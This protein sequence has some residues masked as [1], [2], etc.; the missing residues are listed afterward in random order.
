MSL[1]KQCCCDGQ[2]EIPSDPSPFGG[3]ATPNSDW[4]WS[5]QATEGGGLKIERRVTELICEFA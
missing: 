2:T 1:M 5:T 4:S 3:C